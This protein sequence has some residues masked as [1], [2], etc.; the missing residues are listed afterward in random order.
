MS[1]WMPHVR[2][3]KSQ[4]RFRPNSD[5]YLILLYPSMEGFWCGPVV[6]NFPPFL[7]ALI[8]GPENNSRFSVRIWRGTRLTLEKAI[9]E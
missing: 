5:I 9:L 3:A 7:A 6:R 2:D 1:D 4:E 8:A